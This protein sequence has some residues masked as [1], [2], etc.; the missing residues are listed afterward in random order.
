[1]AIAIAF[2][3]ASKGQ[4]LIAVEN[5]STTTFY[6]R[7]DSA[8]AQAANGD[9]MHLPGGSLQRQCL[10]GL[11]SYSPNLVPLERRWRYLF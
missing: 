7:F 4:N 6:L 11:L 1:M 3:S 2:F 8:L 5:G 10:Y 9:K